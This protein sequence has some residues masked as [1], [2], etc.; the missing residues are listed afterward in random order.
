VVRYSSA[1]AYVRAYVRVCACAWARAR[2]WGGRGRKIAELCYIYTYI[3]PQKN[4]KL[5]GPSV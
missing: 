1:C 4:R 3:G 5:I 2:A